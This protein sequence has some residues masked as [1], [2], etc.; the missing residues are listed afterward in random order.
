MTDV[1]KTRHDVLSDAEGPLVQENPGFRFLRLRKKRFDAQY[2][3]DHDDLM[4]SIRS[5]LERLDGVSEKEREFLLKLTHQ[6]ALWYSEDSVKDLEMVQRLERYVRVERSPGVGEARGYHVLL[7]S[8]PKLG[9]GEPNL[10][11]I[12]E[13]EVAGG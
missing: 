12:H 3:R 5:A 13:T 1:D 2:R 7:R 6:R 8:Q 9:W 4:G 11:G 10:L